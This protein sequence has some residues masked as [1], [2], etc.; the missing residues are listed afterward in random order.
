MALAAYDESFSREE[1]KYMRKNV[2]DWLALRPEPDDYLAYERMRRVEAFLRV[3]RRKEGRTGIM[4]ALD[5]GEV[6]D[7]CV[8][9]LVLDWVVWHG[10]HRMQSGQYI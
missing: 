10:R 3:V 5:M 6:K 7:G 4:Y 8:P 1:A 2:L 9:R